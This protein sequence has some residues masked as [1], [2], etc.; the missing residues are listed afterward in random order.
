MMMLAV[1]YFVSQHGNNFIGRKLLYQRIVKHN[2]FFLAK[3]CKV[4]IRLRTALGIVQHINIGQ[5][6]IGFLCKVLYCSS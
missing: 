5:L 1:P 3:T 6:E 4:G 2:A